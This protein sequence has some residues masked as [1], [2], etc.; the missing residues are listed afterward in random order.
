MLEYGL[1]NTEFEDEEETMNDAIMDGLEESPGAYGIWEG[2]KTQ[3]VRW[4]EAG[5]P[6]LQLACP[7]AMHHCGRADPC[8]RISDWEDKKGH[9]C[10]DGFGAPLRHTHI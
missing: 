10:R 8:A 9:R 2:F 1:E 3:Q 4:I 5:S 6:V 7:K